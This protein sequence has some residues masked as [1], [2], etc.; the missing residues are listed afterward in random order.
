MPSYKFKIHQRI[1]EFYE[2]VK[3]FRP[4]SQLLIMLIG[5]LLTFYISTF[6]VNSL[7]STAFLML[8]I[9]G[10]FWYKFSQEII[11]SLR[12]PSEVILFLLLFFTYV[13][14]GWWIL[15]MGERV[16][17]S[18]LPGGIFLLLQI[19]GLFILS[20]L[21]GILLSQNSKNKI[22][23]MIFYFLLGYVSL[24]ILRFN[25]PP[26]WWYFFQV[27][28]F[29]L[30]LRKTSWAELLT[31]AECWLAVLIIFIFYMNFYTL[32]DRSFLVLDSKTFAWYFFPQILYHFLKLYLLAVLVKIPF[33]LVYH[34]ASLHRKL[35]IAGW[36]QSSIP[37]FIQ[38]IILLLLFYFF[39]SAWQ[40]ENLK[41][42]MLQILE[43]AEAD[44]RKSSLTVY[45]TSLI[46]SSQEIQI[47]GYEKITLPKNLSSATAIQL[48]KTADSENS[49]Y[50]IF[51]Q[52]KQANN[53]FLTLVKIDSFFL[54]TLQKNFVNISANGLIVYPFTF[55]S[56][57]SIFYRIRG[58]E[59][60]K[61]QSEIRVYPFG[62]VPYTFPGLYSVRL[63]M[64]EKQ[65]QSLRR[66]NIK[67]FNQNVFTVGRVYAPLVDYDFQKIGYWN[68]EMVIVLDTAFFKSP[69]MRQ[70]LFWL[71]IYFLINIFIIQR[72]IKFGNRIKEMIIQKFTVLTQGIRQISSGNLDYKISMEGEDEFVEMA[73]RFNS[74]GSELQKKISDLRE[75]DRLEYELRI[76]RQVQLSLLPQSLPPIP[77]Y[78]IKAYI[79]TA[80]EVGGDFYDVLKL[81]QDK[82]LLVL[83]DVSGKGTSA[84]FYMAQ[85]ISLIRFAQQFSHDPQEI[86][87]RLNHYFSDPMIDR[88]IFLTMVLV[89]L[90]CKKHQAT[91]YR[92]GHNNPLF[93]PVDT[94]QPVK[95]LMIP[96]LAIGLERT[97]DLF[98][99]LLAKKIINLEKGDTLFLYTD[100]LIDA[101][102][103]RE[104]EVLDSKMASFYGEERLINLLDSLRGKKPDEIQ[105]KIATELE[106]F[107]GHSPLID[108]ITLL[109]LQRDKK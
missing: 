85:C 26:Y 76:A 43:T 5:W 47:S 86:L 98:N 78:S 56:W 29:L 51:Y 50:F 52:Q 69:L 77:E 16:E 63:G 7:F 67:I 49:D 10:Y 105:Q 38:L 96:G 81:D 8:I 92:A 42:T 9:A 39:I 31:Q 45:Q 55:Q 27:I 90:D 34:H 53:V 88:Q 4:S 101:Y 19:F 35:Q 80:T 99:Q 1:N 33:V 106:V 28:L 37:Q 12:P 70:F 73:E 87:R 82:F 32:P 14:F 109:I 75:K 6:S 22:W 68:F 59:S 60:S 41:K 62:L 91:L 94:T 48:K 74:M 17:P 64:D 30:L 66:G 108:D 89:L 11:T 23:F 46:S 57:D 102:A 21:F 2:K 72:V 84:A 83:G 61:S 58:W 25:D 15:W 107:Y 18:S 3:T 97:G 40:A 100:G 79:N 54:A 36:L 65:S 24:Q 93:I 71:L 95:E 103:N 20:T 104:K 44:N 13:N